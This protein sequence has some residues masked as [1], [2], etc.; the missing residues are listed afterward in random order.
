MTTISSVQEK[1]YIIRINLLLFFF[2]FFYYET[3]TTRWLN[4]IGNMC[5][6]FIETGWIRENRV[7]TYYKILHEYYTSKFSTLLARE[8][9]CSGTSPPPRKSMNR[10]NNN[11]LWYNRFWQI[12]SKLDASIV[13]DAETHWLQ[14]TRDS[15]ETYVWVLYF[16]FFSKLITKHVCKTY[17]SPGVSRRYNV[18]T[19]EKKIRHYYGA[20][21]KNIILIRG[22]HDG[23][24]E[25]RGRV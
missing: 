5:T 1:F 6:H 4:N 25:H 18:G 21:M 17:N 12:F 3:L 16:I 19:R 8:V 9:S 15:R 24:W 14:Q 7:Y 10:N 22:Q 23:A 11:I 13:A 20:I 2:I